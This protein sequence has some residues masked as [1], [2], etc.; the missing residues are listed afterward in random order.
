MLYDHL[1]F[2]V[3]SI[4]QTR[5][6][7]DAL[8][9]AMGFSNVGADDESVTYYHES[10]DKTLPFFGIIEDASHVANETRTAFAARSR[11]DVD[12]LAAIAR[13]A[14]AQNVEEPRVWHEY[15]ATYYAAFFEDPE[16]NKF[17][18]CCRRIPSSI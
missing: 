10:G 9:T 8:L 13:D 4:A 16:G 18:I 17:E 12:R 14:G 6:F 5:S 11:D 1:D 15:S 7:Y 3:R 2:R